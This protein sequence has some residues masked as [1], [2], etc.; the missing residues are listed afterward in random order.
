MCF[1]YITLKEKQKSRV[2]IYFVF[3]YFLTEMSPIW[4]PKHWKQMS[5]FRTNIV[6]HPRDHFLIYDS[7]LCVRV[8]IGQ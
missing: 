1:Y 3:S 2:Y 6:A 4:K 5:E 7:N 8:G